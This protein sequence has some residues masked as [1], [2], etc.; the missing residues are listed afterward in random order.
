MPGH[1]AYTR[2]RCG[3][4]FEASDERTC[5]MP[6]PW[7][8]LSGERRTH[9]TAIAPRCVQGQQHS[10]WTRDRRLRRLAGGRTRTDLQDLFVSTTDV[11]TGDIGTMSDERAT[12]PGIRRG[13]PTGASRCRALL[14]AFLTLVAA[15][16]VYGTVPPGVMQGYEVKP[17]AFPRAPLTVESEFGM[18][19]YSPRFPHR[20]CFPLAPGARSV[21]SQVQ[22]LLGYLVRTSARPVRSRQVVTQFG[23]LTLDVK[24]PDLLLVPTAV[25]LTATPDPLVPPLLD[26]LQCSTVRASRGARGFTPVRGVQVTDGLETVTVDLLKPARLCV[27]A[28]LDGEDPGAPGRPTPL[29]CYRTQSAAAFGEVDFFTRNPCGPDDGRLTPRP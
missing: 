10:G 26:T 28:D 9:R 7:A 15:G 29:L 27:P 3:Q 23:S 8:S 21:E 1:L 17:G 4:G 6:R 11:G 12:S 22:F 25:S 16:Q 24:H 13:R 19:A 5:W 20:L 14:A 2:S 18:L